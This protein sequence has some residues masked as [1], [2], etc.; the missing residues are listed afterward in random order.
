[1]NRVLTGDVLPAWFGA[2]EMTVAPLPSGTNNDSYAVQG[3]G[4]RFFLRVYRHVFDRDRIQYEHALL[5][6]LSAMNLPFAVPAPLPARSGETL[7]I[8][9]EGARAA[10]FPFLPGMHANSEDPAQLR[11]CGA[12]LAA[13]DAAM[14]TIDLPPASV[15]LLEYGAFPAVHAAAPDP[16]EVIA[17]LSP[18]EKERHQIARILDS[19]AVVAPWLAAQLPGQ[20]VHRDL[21]ASNVLVVDGRVTAVLDFEFARPDIRALDLAASLAAFGGAGWEPSAEH[22]RLAFAEAYLGRLPLSRPEIE[23]IPDLMLLARAAS[24]LHR[25]GRER[26]GSASRDD[27]RARAHALLRR[28]AWLEDHGEAL[29][30]HLLSL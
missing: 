28:A 3:A 18:E 17:G 12:A 25:A 26:M 4:G 11:A 20:I 15:G 5:G 19:L 22:W 8:S 10:L 21:D 13:L 16:S 30:R 1:M 29:V 23:A 14:A 27:V 24:V 2:G 6:R 9:S 7:V